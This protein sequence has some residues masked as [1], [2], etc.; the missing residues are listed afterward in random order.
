MGFDPRRWRPPSGARPVTANLDAL[1]AEN[2]ALRR[3]V[4][5]LQADLQR[6]QLRQRAVDADQPRDPPQ[7]GRPDARARRAPESPG[8][9]HGHGAAGDPAPRSRVTRGAA[10]SI[11]A[12]Q[13]QRWVAAM[14]RQP[15]WAELRIGPPAGL[16]ALIT[17]LRAR[18]WNPALS[19]EEELDRRQGGL[20]ADLGAALRGPHSRG[21]WAV[22]AAFALY[23]P[24]AV[25]WL[26]DEPGRVVAELRRRLQRQ[27]PSASGRRGDDPGPRRGTR[28]ANHSQAGPEA[29]RHGAGAEQRHS[30]AGATAGS[31]STAPP[32]PRGEA[33]T[34]LGLTPA[35]SLAQIKRSFR[36]LAKTHHPDLGGDV[37]MF[38]RLDAAYRLLIGS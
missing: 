22:R 9:D 1:L 19:L 14:E 8:A 25:E 35:A 18:S 2:E 12:A 4:R 29:G 17:E 33:L 5:Q 20:G 31:G 32:D 11:T 26:S 36:R 37:A 27:G 34:L 3:Q 30:K 13:V 23:G 16:R 6:L 24:S 7:R 15:G 38:R 28:T 10:P 21:R